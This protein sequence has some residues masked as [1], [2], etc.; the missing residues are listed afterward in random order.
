MLGRVK[1]RKKE[2]CSSAIIGEASSLACPSREYQMIYSGAPC[3]PPTLLQLNI[4]VT[5]DSANA[6]ELLFLLHFLTWSRRLA[7]PYTT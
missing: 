3:F 6:P 7:L 2:V 4:A 5:N 1:G